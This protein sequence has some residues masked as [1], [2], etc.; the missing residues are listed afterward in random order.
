MKKTR[1]VTEIN[2]GE[3]FK[4]KSDW[5][6]HK[7]LL[8]FA[9]YKERGLLPIIEF[10]CGKGSTPFITEAIKDDNNV[11]FLTV[12]NNAEYLE[13]VKDDVSKVGIAVLVNDYFDFEIFG[14]IGLLFIDCA[15]A[16][17]RKELITKY[18]TKARVI[19]VH[20]TEPGAEYVYGMNDVLNTFKYRLD[21]QPEGKPHTTAVSNF[22]DVT[23]WC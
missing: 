17:I 10:G 22:I 3:L 7:P 8:G 6:S 1:V 12:D 4:S 23:S 2:G 16:E 5:D 13:L 14:E 20:D 21:Y 18:S 9:I 15:P 19:I 11:L